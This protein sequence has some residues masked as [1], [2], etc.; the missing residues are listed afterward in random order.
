MCVCVCVCVC[1]SVC[2]CVCV[3]V[4]VSQI[5]ICSMLIGCKDG[6]RWQGEM[7]LGKKSVGESIGSIFPE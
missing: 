1:V 7:M 2:V 6:F 3:C 5:A 4:C